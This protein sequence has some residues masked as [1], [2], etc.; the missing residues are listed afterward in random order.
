[1]NISLNI[2]RVIASKGKTSVQVADALGVNKGTFSRVINKNPTVDTLERIAI[3][4]G[5]KVGDF[6]ADDVSETPVTPSFTCPHC[7][8]PLNIHID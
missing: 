6:F 2:K 7:G 5:C 4:L 3:V 8:K 1:M